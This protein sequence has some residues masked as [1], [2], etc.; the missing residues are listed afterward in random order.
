MA[1]VPLGKKYWTL[2]ASSS[3]S[4]LGDGMR[5]VA[6]PLLGYTVSQDP[7]EISLILTLSSLSWLTFG[8][9]AGVLVDRLT[10][11][12]VIVFGNG[13][14]FPLVGLFAGLVAAGETQ[15][16]HIYMLAVI[17]PVCEAFADSAAQPAISS[18][19]PENAL[20]GAN[21][22]LF[23]ARML[24]QDVVGSPVAGLLFGISASLPFLLDSISFG[25][26]ALLILLIPVAASDTCEPLKND[27]T[28]RSIISDLKDGVRTIWQ[29]PLLRTI[30]L[31]NA[32]V[33][34]SLLL[35]TAVLVLFAKEDLKLSD[36]SYALLF[37]SAALG[38]VL[39]GLCAPRIVKRMGSGPALACA[40]GVI[41]MSRICFG[42]SVGPVTATAA[43]M[44][45]GVAFALWVVAAS[46]YRQRVT[47]QELQ[48]RVY[49]AALAL[50]HAASVVAALA[51]GFLTRT[52]G[53]RTV[54]VL[55]GVLVLGCALACIHTVRK[56]TRAEAQEYAVPLAGKEDEVTP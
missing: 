26:S 20:E 36:S 4:N 31:T 34:F 11:R 49:S 47:P 17:L 12:R 29:Q 46:S 37:T 56:V 51:S 22:R 10:W 19:V 13:I 28:T 40:I 41:G 8:P 23:T 54:M 33:N 25:V 9:L 53:A 27:R 6:L 18:L 21:S 44:A 30:T 45:A 1:N 15:M 39:G 38:S 55:G 2:W 16:W 52:L 14:R 7:L 32:A 24:A 43:Y 42:L 3:I 48:G 35:G 5:I 50:G